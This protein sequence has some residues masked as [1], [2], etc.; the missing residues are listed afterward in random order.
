[1]GTRNEVSYES[2]KRFDWVAASYSLWWHNLITKVDTSVDGLWMITSPVIA[3][4]SR[5]SDI[6]LP[7]GFE[8][9]ISWDTAIR[10]QVNKQYDQYP[11]MQW[12]V[13]QQVSRWITAIFSRHVIPFFSLSFGSILWFWN[14]ENLQA[15]N[16]N[17]KTSNRAER[18]A[19]DNYERKNDPSPVTGNFKRWL[20]LQRD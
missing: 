15:N 16:S 10:K 7:T 5:V 18:V 9:H 4:H 19:E 13:W 12:L 6:Y 17:P 1:M 20:V 8:L 3:F 14:F 11:T 2:I